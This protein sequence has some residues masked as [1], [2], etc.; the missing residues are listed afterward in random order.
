M[1]L[2]QYGYSFSLDMLAKYPTDNR[3]DSRL[4]VINRADGS[5][6]HRTFKDV[7][8]Y[9][10]TDDIFIFNKSFVFL[11]IMTILFSMNIINF[12]RR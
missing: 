4:M 5:I 9:F 1:K 2:S 11:D 3:D 12:I 8:E 7:I 10:D 6:E